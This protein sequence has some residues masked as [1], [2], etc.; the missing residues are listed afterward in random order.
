MLSAQPKASELLPKYPFPHKH[1]QE[2][3]H[4]QCPLGP[5][6]DDRGITMTIKLLPQ[7][8]SKP[9]SQHHSREFGSG[10]AEGFQSCCWCS[11]EE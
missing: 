6:K 1:T 9:Q 10:T 5:A 11:T 3:A 4:R 7:K 8:Y 2:T